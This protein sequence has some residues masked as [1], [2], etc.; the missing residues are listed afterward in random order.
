MSKKERTCWKCAY[1]QNVPGN[2]HISCVFDW[3]KAKDTPPPGD[4]YGIKSGWYYFPALYDP[5]WMRGDC[6]HWAK[7]RDAAF[8]KNI[9]P[10][11][12]M[13]SIFG[14]VGRL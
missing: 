12:M 8:A 2:A 9:D 5:T 13:A 3:E 10:M 11:D 14:S 6:A 1:R 4:P 7:E